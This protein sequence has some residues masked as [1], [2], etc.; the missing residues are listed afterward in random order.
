MKKITAG[1]LLLA[2]PFMPDPNFKRSVVLIC[3]H[4]EHGTFGFVLSRKSPLYLDQAMDN[5]FNFKAPLFFGGPVQTDTLHYLHKL[6]NLEGAV[7]VVPG[8]FWGGDFNDLKELINGG[9]VNPKDIRFFLGYSGWSEGQLDEEMK[10][11]SWL[12][13][14]VRPDHIFDI[15]ADDLWKCILKEKGGDYAIMSNFPEDPSLN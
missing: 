8:L 15:P 2:E 13:H 12:V 1:S 6:E 10:E 5:I 11:H 3:D 7:E 9:E 14:Q 4:G